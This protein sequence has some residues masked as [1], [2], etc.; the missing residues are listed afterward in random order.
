MK[1]LLALSLSVALLGAGCSPTTPVD[2]SVTGTTPVTGAQN[3]GTALASD[4]S[5]PFFPTK[6]GFAIDYKTGFAGTASTYK[7]RIASATDNK[8]KLVYEFP[9]DLKIEQ[10]LTCEAGLLKALGYVDFGN[11]AAGKVDL[12]TKSADGSFLPPSLDIGTTWDANF[13]VEAKPQGGVLAEA[14]ITSMLQTIKTKNKVLGKESVTVAA[15]TFE[16]YKVEQTVDIT[17]TIAGT[18]T[19]PIKATSYAWWAKDVGM[20]KS[21]SDI[22][23]T[24]SSI[25]ATK[26]YR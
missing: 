22:E 4:C 9:E 2:S 13:V 15:G 3:G 14:G 24:A 11:S 1:K 23:G 7:M 25:E 16:A 21:S 10:N 12:E 6:E 20:V 8:L 5:N 18:A 26:I 17:V 19:T